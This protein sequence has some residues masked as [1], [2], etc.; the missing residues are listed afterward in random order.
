MSSFDK[1]W[2]VFKGFRDF[3]IK[4]EPCS[5][6]D[7]SCSLY[8][9]QWGCLVNTVKRSAVCRRWFR[10][11]TI[12]FSVAFGWIWISDLQTL[13]LN[14][15]TYPG[16]VMELSLSGSSWHPARFLRRNP[17]SGNPKSQDTNTATLLSGPL[18]EFFIKNL[19]FN[20]YNRRPDR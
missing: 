11:W 5:D 10:C 20:N 8:A 19:I 18:I 16:L 2:P 14:F 13:N 3:L 9:K 17:G 12:V 1:I 4:N 7:Q 6:T 15:N